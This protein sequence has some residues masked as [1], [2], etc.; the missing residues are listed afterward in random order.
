M[1][2]VVR[3]D[4]LYKAVKFRYGLNTG[5]FAWILHRLTGLALV[6]YLLLHLTVLRSLAKGPDS[7]NN[8]MAKMNI[9]IFKIL[10]VGLFGVFVY[11]GLNGIRVI[12]S[13]FGMESKYHKGLFWALFAVVII[14][15][16]VGGYPIIRHALH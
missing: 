6:L 15:V 2:E 1:K 10:E 8:L 16:L 9:L 13:D 5:L 12:M 3:K 4:V 14:V 7:F 11:H